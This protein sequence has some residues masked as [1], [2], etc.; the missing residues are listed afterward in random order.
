MVEK[1][2]SRC[3]ARTVN[4]EILIM[5]AGQ[6][7][8][9]GSPKQ[10]AMIGNRPMLQGVVEEA[11]DTG[12]RVYVALG[13]HRQQI[14]AVALGQL[15]SESII[16][17]N[18]WAEGLGQSIAESVSARVSTNPDLDG[19][20]ILLGDQ[21]LL[22]SEDLARLLACARRNPE[23]IIA[24]CYDKGVGDDG[25][26][27]SGKRAGVPAY[28]PRSTFPDLMALSGDTGAKRIVRSRPHDTIAFGQLLVDV[29]VPED[30]AFC[31][32]ALP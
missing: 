27:G 5:A 4:I 8:R 6:A 30:L 28:F 13:A 17:V 15:P 24:S 25:N 18:G 22:R 21:P 2:V 20:L 19:V 26:S 31:S 32:G 29:D 9:F 14:L 10:L 11:M 3:S 1:A 7:K 23:R 12:C 16:E